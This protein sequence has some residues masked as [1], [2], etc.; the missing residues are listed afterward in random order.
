MNE[1]NTDANEDNFA[2][3]TV[4]ERLFTAELLEL[5]DAAARR[6]DRD[7]LITLLRRVALSE[8]EAAATADALLARPGSYGY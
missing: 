1:P 2:G 8:T 3:M 7:G 5:F 4:N 6:R